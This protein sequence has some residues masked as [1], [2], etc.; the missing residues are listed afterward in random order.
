MILGL[1]KEMANRQ[2]SHLIYFVRC[3]SG[4]LSDR[5]ERPASALRPSGVAAPRAI[6]T[7]TRCAIGV[8]VHG[9]CRAGTW[10]R[11]G[12]SCTHYRSLCARLVSHG[13]GTR[14]QAIRGRASR[15]EAARGEDVGDLAVCVTSVQARRV[16][17]GVLGDRASRRECEDT[18]RHDGK[19]PVFWVP[20]FGVAE[21]RLSTLTQQRAAQLAHSATDWITS[22]PRQTQ[23]SAPSKAPTSCYLATTYRQY[24]AWSLRLRT[25]DICPKQS[26]Q[27]GP[28]PRS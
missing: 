25:I 11:Q 19:Q 10:R 18:G 23:P 28:R 14:A 6:C 26:L 20:R 9:M 16:S 1:F 17:G 2:A 8:T 27:D 5:R 21:A 13:R 24:C 7:R 3:R 4:D 15:S 12:S 22:L